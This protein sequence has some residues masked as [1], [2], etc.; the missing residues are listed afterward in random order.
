MIFSSSARPSRFGHGGASLR[1]ELPAVQPLPRS[2][3]RIGTPVFLVVALFALPAAALAEEG[4]LD[5]KC[6]VDGAV[7]F[8][9]GALIGEAPVLEI[10][11]AGKHQIRVERE[12]YETHTQAVVLDADTTVEVVATLRRVLPGLSIEVDVD[13]AKVFLDGEQIGTGSVL[14][15]PS[16]LGE[17][18]LVVEGGD[19][20][21]YEGKLNLTAPRMTPVR[22]KLRGSLGTLVVHS[23][24][25]G[26]RVL[27]D[28]RDYG[29]TPVTI[30]PIQPGSHSVRI[31]AD[32]TSDVLQAV[33]V[34]SGKSVTVDAVLVSEGG[35]LDVRPSPRSAV[36]F[37][38]GVELGAGR[39]VI[40]PVK[41]GMYSIRATA[42]GHTDFI[43]PAQVDAGSKTAVAARL[44][45]FD[46]QGPLAGGGAAGKPVHKR[47]GFWVGIGAGAA[48][49]VAGVVVA[50]A[51]TAGNEPLDPIIIPGTDPPPT[52]YTWSLP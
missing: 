40:G 46:S 4:I 21:R 6:N 50:V 3:L 10:I 15:D 22:V 26:A 37:V 2:V 49:V 14:V 36:V 39:Q 30:D 42:P 9:D 25:E 16:T 28:G 48:A 35:V 34:D 43:Q 31:S 47:P 18:T 44:Q 1:S 20:G 23:N 19:F 41:P 29:L 33:V 11:P 38:N 17:H 7:V 51:A 8:V 12:A 32:G 24:P 5:V 27:L 52:T 45:A 13:S